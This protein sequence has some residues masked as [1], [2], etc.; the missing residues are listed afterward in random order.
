MGEIVKG[1]G[2][3]PGAKCFLGTQDA[4]AFASPYDS[5]PSAIDPNRDD[6]RHG[7]PPEYPLVVGMRAYHI[8]CYRSRWIHLPPDAELPKEHLFQAYHAELFLPRKPQASFPFVLF[9]C[10]RIER[11]PLQWLY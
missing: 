7:V 1:R 5:A 6:T 3:E 9:R 4:C 8:R 11:E 10:L 2:E